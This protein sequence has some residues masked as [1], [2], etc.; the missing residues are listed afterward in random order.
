[1]RESTYIKTFEMRG[2]KR[3][4]LLTSRAK[5]LELVRLRLQ[6]PVPEAIRLAVEGTNDLAVLG[7]WFAAAA[8][9]GTVAELRAAMK[10]EP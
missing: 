1:M 8:T 7:K 3:G 2:K 9:A 4:A 5:L 6:D 10:L